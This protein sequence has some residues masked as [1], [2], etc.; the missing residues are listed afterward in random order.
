MHSSETIAMWTARFCEPALEAQFRRDAFPKARRLAM[1]FC[2]T[3]LLF[4]LLG[5]A[6]DL[7]VLSDPGRLEISL[8]VR[9]V[10]AAVIVWVFWRLDR[11]RRPRQLLLPMAV[12][13][14]VSCA[15]L[16]VLFALHPLL[17]PGKLAT[18]F[19]LLYAAVVPL[20]WPGTILGGLIIEAMLI[21][22]FGAA[23]V[24]RQFGLDVVLPLV[25]GVAVFSALGL[26]IAYRH[27]HQSR[28]DYLSL[29]N[30]R[31]LRQAL[32]EKTREAEA[33]ARAKSNFLAVMSHEIRTPMNGILGM[34]RLMLD[35]TMAP[36][37]RTRL[38]TL[39]HSAEALLA[40]L[41]DILDFSK[42]EAGRLDFEAIAFAPA[43]LVNDVAQ[44]M[45]SRAEEKGLDL[46]AEVDP[47][48]PP[49]LR[50]DPG[51]LRQV[52]LN[53]A[54]NAVKFTEQGRVT[55]RMTRIA[56]ADGS[57]LL[58]CTV[59]DTGIGLDDEAK[60]RLFQSFAQADASIS[61]R[62]GGT[63]LG[64]AI[65][66]RLVEGQGGAIGVESQAGSGSCFWFRLPLVSASA[67]ALADHFAV[68]SDLPPLTVLL[69]EDN[70]INQMVARGFLQRAGHRVVVANNG[71]E[72]LDL[73]RAG[74]RFDVVLMDMQMPEM[75]GLEAARAIRA[76]GGTAADLPIIALTANAMRA[77]EERCRAAGMDDFVAKPL[78]P[79]R[80]FAAMGR[81]LG[82]SAAVAGANDRA[83]VGAELDDADL[84]V[85]ERQVGQEQMVE[86]VRL[87][88]SAGA[89]T[90]ASLGG[91]DA[92]RD[93][94]DVIRQ[95][96]HDLKGMAGYVGAAP[97]VVLA[98][99]IEE[100]A[101]D[102]NREEVRVLVSRLDPIWVAVRGWL[103]ER[104]ERAA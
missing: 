79:D 51:R 84:A 93:G 64:L 89:E 88:L 6:R 9:G 5:W 3:W 50:G 26:L 22:A 77:D 45:R 49:W 8:L 66:K 94:L 98:A 35:E 23:T 68:V 102:G 53:L 99:A 12:H 59:T 36:G 27:H 78:D 11:A 44:L 95:H 62:Y 86:I 91:A 74:S 28:C 4:Y 42:L 2:L 14:G 63:G 29:L 15:A 58:E 20:F 21:A 34:A 85:V 73:V 37:Q 57:P 25:G 13:H 83:P 7:I 103:Q 17:V 39:R 1:G 80:L 41:D 69:A 81:V 24:W 10:G 76:L 87:F 82:D 40:I 92:E 67:P 18:S 96:A 31:H 90:C 38:D 55:L 65:C 54:G 61:R 48:L 104:L 52:L 72:A 75:D 19:I 56:G 30:E 71:V 46:V 47:D 100:A 97:L 32:E 43:P 16:G 101:R 70:A 60:A 33:A